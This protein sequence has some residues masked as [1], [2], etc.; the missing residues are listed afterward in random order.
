MSQLK[1]SKTSNTSKP[2]RLGPNQRIKSRRDY[3]YVQQ[4]GWKQ[5]TKYILLCAVPVIERDRYNRK[6]KHQTPRIGITVTTKVHK[7]AV[8]RNRFKRVVREFFR[9]NFQ[10]L[11]QSADIVVIALNE[12]CNLDNR[13]LN[14]ELKNLFSKAKLL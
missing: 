5:R 6:I 13:Q 11:K 2:K 10:E 12:V 1:N 14:L 3:L 8:E 7:R 4:H 9:E